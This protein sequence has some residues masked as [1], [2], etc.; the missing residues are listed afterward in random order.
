MTPENFCYWLQGLF[1]VGNPLTLTPKQ[2][3]QIKDH[4]DL[5]FTKVTP[6]R[7]TEDIINDQFK[8][9]SKKKKN[10]LPFDPSVM[11]WTPKN[12][13]KYCSKINDLGTRKIC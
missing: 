1:E 6:D 10:E 4:L 12:D 5:V 7:S 2:I 8:D 13:T 3:V 9:K 11:D